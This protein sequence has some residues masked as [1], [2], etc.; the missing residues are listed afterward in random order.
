MLGISVGNA[1][2]A[3]EEETIAKAQNQDA[4]KSEDPNA[5]VNDGDAN[6]Q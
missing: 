2:I 1:N 6:E 5:K 3:D 4:N